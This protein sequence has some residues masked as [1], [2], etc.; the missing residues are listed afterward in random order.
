M[1]RGDAW[2]HLESLVELPH[3]AV[4]AGYVRY[5]AERGVV[6]DIGCGAGRLLSL[7]EPHFLTY[8]GVDIS[9]EA[10]RLASA[11]KV[12]GTRFYRGSFEHWTPTERADVI[13]FNESIYYASNPASM[14]EKYSRYLNAD[15]RII[16]SAVYY[17]HRRAMWRRMEKTLPLITASI[18]ENTDQNRWRIGVFKA[19]H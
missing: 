1:F 15:G 6:W 13:V 17:R 7:L 18:V 16:V 14:L 19:V 2:D 10:I 11:R 5:C 12:P 8:V 9:D 3:Y 4:V